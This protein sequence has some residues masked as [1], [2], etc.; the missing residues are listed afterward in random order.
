MQRQATFP[1]DPAP[2]QRTGPIGVFDSGV[3]GL[4]VW[5]EILRQLPHESTVYFADQAHV[6]Y[7][8]RS[9]E[10]IRQFCDAIARF[11]LDRGCKAIVVACNTASAAALKHLRETFPQ[12]PIIGME[13]AVKPAAA[14]TRTGVVGIMATPATF[15]GRLFQAT[16]GRLARG[17]RLVNQ[18][19]DGLAEAVEAGNLDGAETEALL[20]GFLGPILEANADTIVLACTHY[21]FVIEPIR[22]IAGEHVN[23]I[24]PA[25]AIARHLGQVLEAQGLAATPA[26]GAQHRFVTTGAGREFAAALVRLT[27]AQGEVTEMCWQEERAAVATSASRLQLSRAESA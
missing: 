5:R 20:R 3:G 15:Q 22:R 1:A 21:P 7:G 26:S 10:Q 11:L 4:S 2:P 6:P 14:S 23:V 13:P 25:P 16:A 27:G 19:C 8:P 12:V 24:D 18:V 9:Q 17:I